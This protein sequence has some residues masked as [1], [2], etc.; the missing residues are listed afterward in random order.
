MSNTTPI[1]NKA[2]I[3]LEESIPL[4]LAAVDKNTGKPIL[5]AVIS[6]VRW[7]QDNQIGQ[8]TPTSDPN[9]YLFAPLKAGTVT[10]TANALVTTP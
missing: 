8:I 1:V 5:G 4:I 10:I 9:T 3:D 2:T 6:N 7:S